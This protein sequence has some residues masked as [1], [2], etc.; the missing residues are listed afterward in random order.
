VANCVQCQ[1]KTQL[2]SNGVPLCPSCDRM[3]LE[4]WIGDC[5]MDKAQKSGAS[6]L[7]AKKQSI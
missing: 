6:P 3:N 1:A 4:E 2:H 7:K 5:D